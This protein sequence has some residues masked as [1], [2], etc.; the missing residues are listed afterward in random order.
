M[1]YY[2]TLT[3]LTGRNSITD[4]FSWALLRPQYVTYQIWTPAEE[5]LPRLYVSLRRRQILLSCKRTKKGRVTPCKT[6]F[7]LPLY[8]RF[9]AYP[10]A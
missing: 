6:P 10:S 5:I 7:P 1:S 8:A 3:Y 9:R 2:R 4:I